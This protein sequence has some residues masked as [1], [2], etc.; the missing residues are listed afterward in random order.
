MGINF[1]TIKQP[2][3]NYKML[4][5]Q[6]IA[7]LI[8]VTTSATQLTAEKPKACLENWYRRTMGEDFDQCPEAGFD[9]LDDGYCY[10]S[11]PEGYYGDGEYCYE[12]C[13]IGW[14]ESG[15][16]NYCMKPMRLDR[17]WYY[18]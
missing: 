18:N 17:E 10:P 9:E 16:R 6:A 14:E 11:C 12:E 8:A 1:K 13:P 15:R 3:T 4:R 2:H 5:T 7:A